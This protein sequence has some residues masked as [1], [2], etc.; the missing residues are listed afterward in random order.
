MKKLNQKGFEHLTLI[1]LV[2]VIA[3]VSAVGYYV[4]TK[5]D[6]ASQTDQTTVVKTEEQT[7]QETNTDTQSDSASTGTNTETISDDIVVCS[8]NTA[9][10]SGAGLK[11]AF[12]GYVQ[13]DSYTKTWVE[14]GTDS[15]TLSDKTQ[16]FPSSPDSCNEFLAHM[17]ADGLQ[18]KYYYRVAASKDNGET[19]YSKTDSFIVN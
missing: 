19:V 13:N 3:L 2:L 16:E 5:R 17:P 7:T 4:W 9:A 8:V 11:V 10:Q 15:N 6:T 12:Y 1:G 14:Y 18:G